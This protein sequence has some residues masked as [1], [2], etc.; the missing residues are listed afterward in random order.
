M[1][2][3]DLK[4]MANAGGGKV[5]KPLIGRCLCLLGGNLLGREILS[6]LPYPH[7][8]T[9][10]CHISICCMKEWMTKWLRLETI[11]E[12]TRWR[13]GRQRSNPGR[14]GK[15]KGNDSMIIEMYNWTLSETTIIFNSFFYP[16]IY[17][18]DNLSDKT[19]RKVQ[20]R[21]RTIKVGALGKALVQVESHKIFS[22]SLW[23]HSS[24]TLYKNALDIYR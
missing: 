3:S 23:I 13:E 17:K 21:K 12:G 15:E 16:Q 9:S 22:N 1:L 4:C 2:R 7:P 14:K 18:K 10:F 11:T 19:V 24:P 8:L 6:S 20:G 5:G